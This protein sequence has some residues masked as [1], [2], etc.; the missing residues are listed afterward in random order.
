MTLLPQSPRMQGVQVY[1]T[2]PSHRVVSM[3]VLSLLTQKLHGALG[4]RGRLWGPGRIVTGQT[5]QPKA[6]L[7]SLC[8][9]PVSGFCARSRL[10]L[11]ILMSPYHSAQPSEKELSFSAVLK[12]ES[13]ALCRLDK[14]STTKPHP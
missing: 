13:R 2:V 7:A 9:E 8:A 10:L 5:G 3:L 12:M 14:R 6:G 11:A 4:V 1:D